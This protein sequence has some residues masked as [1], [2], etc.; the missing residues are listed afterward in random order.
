MDNDAEK[1]AQNQKEYFSECGAP[2][3]VGPYSTEGWTL[4]N[5]TLWIRAVHDDCYVCTHCRPVTF[6]S[7]GDW[8]EQ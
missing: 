7:C 2:K 1:N 6:C 5:A 3:F 8:W 4:L